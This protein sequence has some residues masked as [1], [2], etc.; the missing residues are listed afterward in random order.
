MF[1][2][3]FV[4][5]LFVFLTAQFAP[6]TSNRMF[7]FRVILTIFQLFLSILFL[8]SFIWET[9]FGDVSLFLFTSHLNL[10]VFLFLIP[11][12]FLYCICEPE[13]LSRRIKQT[14]PVSFP[15]RLLAFPF[16]TGAANAMV[17][18]VLTLFF[19]GVILAFQ[20]Q[21]RDFHHT[22]SEDIATPLLCVFFRFGLLMLD[23][24]ATTLLIYHLLLRRWISRSWN[25]VFPF[26]FV[27]VII[28]FLVFTNWIASQFLLPSFYPQ[29]FL[30]HLKFL[31]TP[32]LESSVS[33]FSMVW[34]E[35][36]IG[37]IWFLILAAIG[38]RWLYRR[39]NAFRRDT[40]TNNQK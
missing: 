36:R 16:Y 22:S 10:A 31:P 7:P 24:C 21:F 2:F 20:I 26:V 33:T 17:W 13:K 15:K 11:F 29:K 14:I 19:E 23:Y 27:A 40:G 8:I 32:R 4:T 5:G 35:L 38:F 12:L 1:S 30:N 25:W 18:C 9:T 6:A 28:L 3:L 34:D 39:F 37:V